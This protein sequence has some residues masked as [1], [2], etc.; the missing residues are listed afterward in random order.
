MESLRQ[1]GKFEE[2]SVPAAVEQEKQRRKREDR[3][4]DLEPKVP[5]S[6]PPQADTGD[7]TEQMQ[8]STYAERYQ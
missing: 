2:Q 1:T 8:A 6:A 4:A 5:E 3:K 7:R